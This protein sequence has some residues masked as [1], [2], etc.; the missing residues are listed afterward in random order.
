MLFRLRGWIVAPQWRVPSTLDFVLVTFAEE[1]EVEAKVVFC[2]P[3]L[4]FT[5]LQY[6]PRELYATNEEIAM[7][8]RQI[9][10]AERE[11]ELGT[12]YNLYGLGKHGKQLFSKSNTLHWFK[13]IDTDEPW[14]AVFKP[15]NQ[16][17]LDISTVSG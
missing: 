14:P 15:R 5:L 8:V 13:P 11:P 9:V 6:D 16:N 7:Q 12:T 1:V 3:T 4:Q 2:H 10:A 17:K